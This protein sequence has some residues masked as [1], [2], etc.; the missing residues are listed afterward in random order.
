MDDNR[1]TEDAVG[2]DFDNEVAVSSEKK[3]INILI[4]YFVTLGGAILA[5]AATFIPY[6]KISNLFFYRNVSIFTLI[7]ES[8]DDPQHTLG[9]T[10]DKVL[11]GAFIAAI[12]FNLLVVLFAGLKKMVPA[13]VFTVLAALPRLIPGNAYIHY[14]GL[15]IALAGAIWYK[16]IEGKQKKNVN[17]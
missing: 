14:L 6:L 12:V 8:L 9:S 3:G 7:M 10:S 15:A 1:L 17:Q 16:V 5:L 13:I 11:F 4:P 2:S